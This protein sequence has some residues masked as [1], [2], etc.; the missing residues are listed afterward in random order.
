MHMFKITFYSSMVFGLIF[1]LFSLIF[2]FGDWNRLVFVFLLGLFVGV[3]AAPTFE[4]K[5][6]KQAWIFQTL[7]G[8]LFG[9]TLGVVLNL[10]ISAIAT[11]SFVCTFLGFTAP[12]WLKHIPI[13]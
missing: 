10:E 6:F 13:P 4:P 7:G 12:L 8:M 2:Y 11:L 9:L 5:A 1:S 3:I